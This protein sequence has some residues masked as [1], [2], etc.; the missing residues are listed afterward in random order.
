MEEG[1]FFDEDLVKNNKK[2]V[3]CPNCNR[4]LKVGLNDTEFFCDE[5]GENFETDVINADSD[6]FVWHP[7]GLF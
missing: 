6:D 5:C 1:T 4:E 3:V 7:S 2:V